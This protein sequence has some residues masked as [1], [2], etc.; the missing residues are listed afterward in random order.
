MIYTKRK[1]C[2]VGEILTAEFLEPLEINQTQLAEAMGVARRT[3]NEL[4]N[5]R[6]GVTAET[7]L[8]LAKVFGNSADFWLNLQRQVDIWSAAN[9]AKFKLR[10]S[11]ARPVSKIKKSR[12]QKKPAMSLAAG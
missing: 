10:I 2:T 5:G 8:L 9:N 6:R 4:C 7:A 3:V 1:P 12:G 11:K